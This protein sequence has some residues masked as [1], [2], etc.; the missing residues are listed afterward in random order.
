MKKS[1][2][3]FLA[4]VLLL[5]LCLSTSL[6]MAAPRAVEP[7]WISLDTFQIGISPASGSSNI[8]AAA[9]VTAYNPTHKL[10]LTMTL[11]FRQ[12]QNFVS[13]GISWTSSGNGATGI[14]KSVRMSAGEYMVQATV[15]L[16]TASGEYIETVTRN[17]S[18][19]VV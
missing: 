13:T 19:V 16:T 12:G 3:R 1:A 2:V 7:R 5:V 17:S 15:V 11:M 14:D 8:R 10:N 9:A 18:S 6:A 4:L